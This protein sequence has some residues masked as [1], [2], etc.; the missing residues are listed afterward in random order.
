MQYADVLV[1]INSLPS[2]YLRPGAGFTALQ[3]ARAA[4]LF[5]F[6]NAVDGLTQ[7]LTFSAASGVW[8]DVWGRLFGISRNTQEADAAYAGRISSTLVAGR[9]TPVAMQIY[10]QAALGISATIV[11]DFAHTSW[12]LST[13]I[14]LSAEQYNQVFAGLVFVRPAGVPSVAVAI[15]QGGLYIDSVNFMG[16]PKT[17]G[18]YLE[19]PAGSFSL[20]ANAYTNNSKAKLPTLFLSDPTI[21]PGIA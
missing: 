10:L 15:H 1:Q 9:A 5:R 14:E 4:G 2:T 19:T 17:T 18:A 12:E 16:A 7:Q 20:S 11:E 21:N 6:T 8:L 13:T 3:A